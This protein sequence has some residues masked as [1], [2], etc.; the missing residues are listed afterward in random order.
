MSEEID[1]KIASQQVNLG[2]VASVSVNKLYES[3]SRIIGDGKVTAENVVNIT[4]NLMQL[5][6]KYTG[7]EGSQKKALVMH[8]L[9]KFIRDNSDNKNLHMVVDTII[10]PLIDSVI[11]LDK[12]KVSI[13]I[14]GFFNKF[15][16]CCLK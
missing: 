16:P 12:K 11:D 9:S 5:V 6:E 14:K 3:L 2:L 15:S 13:Q 10:P 8:V 1:I 7:L 4:I